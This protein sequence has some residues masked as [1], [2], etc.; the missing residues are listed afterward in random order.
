MSLQVFAIAAIL[1]CQCLS[2]C[3]K[4]CQQNIK[5]VPANLTGHGHEDHLTLAVHRQELHAGMHADQSGLA[6]GMLGAQLPAYDSAQAAA[7]EADLETALH[8]TEA[9]LADPD[10]VAAAADAAAAATC[11]VD[12]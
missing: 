1:P 8:W 2:R 6:E 3:D 7:D 9:L 10:T 11:K 4:Q 12:R 5:C